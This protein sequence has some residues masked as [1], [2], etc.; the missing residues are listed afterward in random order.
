MTT[1]GELHAGDVVLGW[2]NQPWGVARRRYDPTF[3][4]TL[5]KHERIVVGYPR[6]AD[7]VSVIQQCDTTAEAEA[8][9]VLH[10]TGFSVEVIE[11][12]WEV[13]SDQLSQMDEAERARRRAH[14][15]QP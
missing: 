2:D 12:S 3:G 13:G 7:E 15:Y 11:E 10:E 8:W 5:V 6:E 9:I 1:W 4:I 14:R